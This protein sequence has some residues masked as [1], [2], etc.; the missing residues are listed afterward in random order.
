MGNL[1]RPGIL[2]VIID[3]PEGKSLEHHQQKRY[4]M[5]KRPHHTMNYQKMKRNM[6]CSQLDCVVPWGSIA[7]G[8]LLCGAPHDKLQRSLKEKEN[9]ANLQR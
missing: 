9:Q 4:H 3:W 6:L 1:S 5:L 8:K 7:D 2:E